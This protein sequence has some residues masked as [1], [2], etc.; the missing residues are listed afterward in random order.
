MR[1]KAHHSGDTPHQT[2]GFKVN[3][4]K[5]IP[6]KEQHEFSR[7][8]YNAQ[9]EQIPESSL[10]DVEGTGFLSGTKLG[11]AIIKKSMEECQENF[12]KINRCP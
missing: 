12:E 9:R 11:I 7:E 5:E 10:K 2:L 3:N 4:E 6:N 8:E 1:R